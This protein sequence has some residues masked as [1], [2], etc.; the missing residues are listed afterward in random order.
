M[1]ISCFGQETDIVQEIVKIDDVLYE[2]SH[3]ERF[4]IDTKHVFV[5]VKSSVKK[6]PDNICTRGQAPLCRE[7]FSEI[8]YG[9]C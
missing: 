9:D 4:V 8:A 7:G 3:G 5:R 6:L 1:S 2:V